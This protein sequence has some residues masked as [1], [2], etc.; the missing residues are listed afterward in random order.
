MKIT[1]FQKWLPAIVVCLLPG[2]YTT[3]VEGQLADT[4]QKKGIAFTGLTETLANLIKSRTPANIHVGAYEI[5]LENI[6]DD[7]I[8]AVFNCDSVIMQY[9][10]SAGDGA[11]YEMLS[12]EINSAIESRFI[13]N[14]GFLYVNVFSDT[15]ADGMYFNISISR[16]KPV[17]IPVVLNASDSSFSTSFDT[18]LT[19]VFNTD[20]DLFVNAAMA[21]ADSQS[22]ATAVRM[23][24]FTFEIKSDAGEDFFYN[25]Y[26]DL[27]QEDGNGYSSF[28][29]KPL[30]CIPF[31]IKGRQYCAAPRCFSLYAKTYWHLSPADA[32][33]FVVDE[34]ESHILTFE[35]IEK[36][37]FIWDES[38]LSSL[39]ANLVMIPADE[40]WD[41]IAVSANRAEFEYTV[42]D[43]FDETSL[44][45]ITLCCDFWVIEGTDRSRRFVFKP[46]M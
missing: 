12:Y 17:S 38:R 3:T 34:G 29:E 10:S 25:D 6:I 24:T 14:D 41:S 15:T 11:T 33:S 40:D 9:L 21:I 2:F 27:E 13:Y 32:G 4:A 19:A 36:G 20:I 39:K 43:L 42:D 23:N 22:R 35:Q 1:F 26:A 46:A 18:T 7:D 8:A 5:S 37:D 44:E 16:G 28:P 31:D 30:K 45:Q